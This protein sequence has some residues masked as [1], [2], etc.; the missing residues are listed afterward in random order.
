MNDFWVKFKF[1]AKIS[2][3]ALLALFVLIFVIRNANE[4]VRIWLLRY[5]DTSVLWLLFLTFCFGALSTLL[6]KTTY[7]TFRQYNQMQERDRLARMEQHLH[8]MRGE[9]AGRAAPGEAFN[10]PA[11][12]AATPAASPAQPAPRPPAA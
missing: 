7:N 1:W 4:P 8:Q 11:G 2:I 9:L 5:Y 3:A 12:S 6:A 10:A